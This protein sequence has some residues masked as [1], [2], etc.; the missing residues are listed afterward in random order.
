MQGI[1]RALSLSFTAGLSALLLAGP[2]L[3]QEA[4]SQKG[5]IPITTSSEEA[6]Q[7]YLKG[8]ALAENLRAT[9]ARGLLQ[10]AVAKDPNFALAHLMLA[11][12]AGTA[13]EFFDAMNRAVVVSGKVSEPERLMI[14]GQDAGVKGDPAG[15]KAHYTRLLSLSP[16]DERAQTAVGTYYFGLQDFA[17]AVEHLR[18]ATAVNPAHAPA[19]NML[20]YSYRSLQK[21]P[22]AEQAFK[23]YIELIPND[24]N[25]YDSYAELLMKTGRFKE[26]IVQYEKALAKD[27]NFVASYVG[28][29][30][31]H[32][33][34]GSPEQA[35][36]S[37]GKL[38]A[39]ARN[40]GE[41]R[42]ALL[43]TAASYVHEGA[44]DKA[45]EAVQRMY[46]LA[47]K[48]GDKAGMSGDLNL[49][50][51]ILLDAGR[52]DEALAK[53]AQCVE[54]IGSADVPEEVKAA[55]RRNGLYDEARVALARK[56]IK[57]A[58]LK[59]EAYAKEV[60]TKQAPFEVR[61]Q[62]QLAGLLALQ[63]GDHA[64]AVA[65]LKQASQQD[66][67]VLYQLGL[68]YQAQGDAAKARE[69]L[70]AAA[71]FNGL[72]FNYAYVRRRAQ[73]ALAKG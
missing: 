13:K 11:N 63:E 72:N 45:L 31:D 7:L 25:P 34:L 35:R 54:A 32:V 21:Y 9:D 27:P 49:M 42:Q 23:K 67:R 69:L 50:G 14:L 5:K 10:Q 4:E 22:E 41:R 57:T 52:P 30:T 8:R 68:A 66:P 39:A 12:S 18:K 16:G 15:Q 29:S 17:S 24:P 26:S 70:D 44:H 40:V 37:L 64:R 19:Y 47:E 46:A 2:A 55:T 3:T 48:D 71:N 38:E 62:H 51:D 53:Y 61:Q 58:R 33:L 1:G 56:D 60:A 28:I 59:A 36:H 20:G 6:R 65:E 73:Q 43:W